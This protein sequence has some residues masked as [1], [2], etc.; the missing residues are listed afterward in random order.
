MHKKTN[1]KR[2]DTELTFAQKQ[3]VI[4]AKS[5]ALFFHH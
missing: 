5:Q 1:H 3:E 2:K 4:D